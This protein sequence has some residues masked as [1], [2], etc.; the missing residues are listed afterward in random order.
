MLKMYVCQLSSTN[1]LDFV[2]DMQKLVG[3]IP[4]GVDTVN[5]SRDHDR[6]KYKRRPALQWLMRWFRY[7]VVY[8]VINVFAEVHLLICVVPMMRSILQYD[9]YVCDIFLFYC[10][11]V[12]CFLLLTN[13]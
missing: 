5:T 4:D 10:E 11:L 12:D 9:F 2:A 1:R 8:C 3:G 7:I 13:M 6:D